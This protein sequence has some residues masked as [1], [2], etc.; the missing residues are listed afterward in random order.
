MTIAKNEQKTLFYEA[1]KDWDLEKL[2]LKMEAVKLQLHQQQLT[3]VDKAC[4]RGLLCGYSSQQ[5]ANHFPQESEDVVINTIWRLSYYLETF[6]HASKQQAEVSWNVTQ[7]LAAAGYKRQAIDNRLPLEF[8]AS[9]TIIDE[10]NSELIF[11]E[12]TNTKIIESAFNPELKLQFLTQ[13]STAKIPCDLRLNFAQVSTNEINTELNLI[14]N[15]SYEKTPLGLSIEPQ[16]KS[17][18]KEQKVENTAIEFTDSQEVS[19]LAIALHA[20]VNQ[21]ALTNNESLSLVES[22][23]FLP[24]IGGW[25]Q[26]GS[27][28]LVGSVGVAIA[29]AAFTPYNVIVKA[30]ATIRP[31]GKI[32]VVQAKTSGTIVSIN[33]EENQAIKQGDIIATIDNSSSKTEKNLLQNQIQQAQLQLQQIEA[34]NSALKRQIVA[35]TNRIQDAV[36]E[37]KIEL[38][39]TLRNYRNEQIT[40]TAQVEEAQANLNLTKAELQQAE[41]ELESAQATMIAQTA[42][43]KSAQSKRERYQTIAQSGALSQD[44]LEEI[45]LAFQQQQQEVFAQ[46]ATVGRYQSAIARQQQAI[47]AAKARLDNMRASLNPSDSEIAIANKRITQVQARG[48]A[49]LANLRREQEVLKQ[50]AIDTQKQLERHQHQL[51]QIIKDSDRHTVKASASGTLFKLNLRNPGQNVQSGAEIAQ[52]API[53]TSLLAK[54]YVSAQNINQVSLG[55]SAQLMISACPYTD[56]GTLKGKVTQI[57]PD[58]IQPENNSSSKPSLYEVTIEPESSTLNQGEGNNR[59]SLQLGMEGKADIIAQEETVLR[60]LLRKARLSVNL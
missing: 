30:D 13:K 47:A 1:A 15:P 17:I 54:A 34:Q 42:A 4:L 12:N 53:N 51:E 18:T 7:K 50:Q 46:Q 20:P 28:F 16:S 38:S 2:Y 5:I 3:A 55:Q 45:N 29:L 56:Y 37:A 58:A 39:R 59:C 14:E 25:S 44:R 8:T 19:P 22:D 11:L 60:F 33:A 35:E 36:A 10:S 40:T 9:E 26:W 6:L 27:L 31:D 24:S 21:I 23:D 43:L 41:A 48:E 49:T 57:S 32:K 52:I